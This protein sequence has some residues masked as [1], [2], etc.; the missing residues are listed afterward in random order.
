MVP[1][2]FRKV[3]N[4]A[5][6]GVVLIPDPVEVEAL[7]EAGRRLVAGESLGRVARWLDAHGPAP[8]RAERWSRM[9]VRQAL[10]G[11]AAGLFTVEERRAFAAAANPG[12]PGRAPG[13]APARLL[14]G[15]LRCGSCG[16]VLR[17][18]SVQ[19]GPVYRCAAGARNDGGPECSGGVTLFASGGERVVSEAWLAGWGQVGETVAERVADSVG[20]ALA[21]AEE[22]VEVLAPVVLEERGAGRVAALAALEEAEAERDRLAALPVSRVLVLR[23]TGR[24]FGDAWSA[25]TVEDRRDLLADTLGSLTVVRGVQGRRIVGLERFADGWRFDPGADR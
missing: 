5:G 22:R 2:G 19:A 25:G 11:H 7:R 3:P 21:V 4:P 24:T 16:R 8:R 20:A 14:S 12:G 6:S 13:R 17:V 10:T 1:Y 23:E 9:T 15:L 18:S